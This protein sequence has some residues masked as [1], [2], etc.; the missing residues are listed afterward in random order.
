MLRPGAWCAPPVPGCRG[1]NCRFIVIKAASGAGEGRSCSQQ[2]KKVMMS[3]GGQHQ[4]QRWE[5]TGS[6][7]D[8]ADDMLPQ[9]YPPQWRSS[10]RVISAVCNVDIG[11]EI[12]FHSVK[13]RSTKCTMTHVSWRIIQMETRRCARA[14][15]REERGDQSWSDNINPGQYPASTPRCY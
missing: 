6:C 15:D 3:D 2:H 13:K 7:V 9:L 12:L 14:G 10:V 8:T 11:L 5:H 4:H 1:K